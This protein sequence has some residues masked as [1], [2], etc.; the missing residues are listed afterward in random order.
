MIRT[1]LTV[2]HLMHCAAL[3]PENVGSKGKVCHFV[4]FVTRLDFLPAS[5]SMLRKFLE[6]WRL[7]EAGS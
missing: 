3:N 6:T 2:S 7:S 1:L 5:I 4:E